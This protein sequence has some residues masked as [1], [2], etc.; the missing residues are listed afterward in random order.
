MHEYI[1]VAAVVSAGIPLY[2][3]LMYYYCDDVHR[4]HKHVHHVPI[5]MSRHYIE[6]ANFVPQLC[7]TLLTSRTFSSKLW[8]CAQWKGGVPTL[9]EPIKERS[10]SKVGFQGVSYV[11]QTMG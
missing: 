8:V 2:L 6:T 4:A 3:F 11:A 1:I 5:Y 9:Q 10:K 7:V